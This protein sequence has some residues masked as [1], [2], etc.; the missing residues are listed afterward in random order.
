[1]SIELGEE[2]K[3][4][5]T[6]MTGTVTQRVEKF[7]GSIQFAVQ[8]RSEDGRTVTDAMILDHQY[9]EVT[10]DGVKHKA[11]TP[12]ATSIQLGQRVRDKA[13]DF[14][15]MAM[16]KSI[17]LNGC[18]YFWVIPKSQQN[19]E[20]VAPVGTYI[21]AERLEVVDQGLLSSAQKPSVTKPG[22]PSRRVRSA[23]PFKG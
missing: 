5:V 16:E 13:S 23:T 9:L 19:K 15:G 18:V 6:G 20:G 8:G 22:G 11:V 21:S 3:C 14:T 10:G 12:V 4:I 17:F 7:N 2:V 1:M